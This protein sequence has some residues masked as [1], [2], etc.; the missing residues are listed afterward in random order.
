MFFAGRCR[1]RTGSGCGVPTR[2]MGEILTN[3]G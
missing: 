3:C 1:Y 2:D